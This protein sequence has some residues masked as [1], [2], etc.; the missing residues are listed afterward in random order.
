M[1][2]PLDTTQYVRI[3]AERVTPLMLDAKPIIYLYPQAPTV[4]SV[5]VTLDGELT[6]T[7]PSHGVDGWQNFTAYPDGTLI[8][9]DGKE[10]Y[11]LYWEGIQNAQWDFSKGWCVRGEDTAA[12]LEWALRE[13]GLTRREANEFIV[14]WLP[15]MQN[16][17]YNVISFQTDTY[18]DG[19]VLDVTPTPDSLLRVFMAYYPTDTEVDIQPQ[20]LEGFERQGFTVVEWG[21]TQVREP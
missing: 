10:Y 21:G 5:R 3:R 15:L 7:Y 18:T 13:Q 14:Y 2:R 4:C 20:A 1:E 12:F 6:C 11:A 8:F 17:P 9:P 16:N 19:A